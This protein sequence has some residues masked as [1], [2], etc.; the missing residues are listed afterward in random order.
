[1]HGLIV[2]LGDEQGMHMTDAGDT[3]PEGRPTTNT[4]ASGRRLSDYPVREYVAAMS[5]ELAQLARGDGDE[6]LAC[7]LEAASAIA[8]ERP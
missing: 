6:R 1:M 3:G 8:E 7:L 5:G 4:E 2:W